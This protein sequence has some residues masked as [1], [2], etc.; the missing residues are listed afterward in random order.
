MLD[1]P[2]WMFLVNDGIGRNMIKMRRC[3]PKTITLTFEKFVE[4]NTPRALG[5]PKR[6]A[7]TNEPRTV[8][9]AFCAAVLHVEA[10]FLSA[11][12]PQR[13]CARCGIVGRRDARHPTGSPQ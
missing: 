4:R 5:A 3:S 6:R 1:V 8:I 10:L 13:A 7:E 2:C 11:G 12:L 9:D